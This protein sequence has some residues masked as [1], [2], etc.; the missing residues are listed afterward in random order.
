MYRVV[1]EFIE[2]FNGVTDGKPMDLKS[3]KYKEYIETQVIH[4]YNWYTVPPQEGEEWW[5]MVVE[6]DVYGTA[7]LF[8]VTKHITGEYKIILF[9]KKEA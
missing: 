2:A 8:L 5:R 6:M 1:Q 3:Q 4:V 7:L 9:A